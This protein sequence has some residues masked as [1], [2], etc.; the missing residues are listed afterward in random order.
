MKVSVIIPTYNY[1]RFL[2]ESIGSVQKQTVEDVEILVVDDGSTDDTPEIVQSLAAEDPRVEYLPMPR[3]GVS[4][5]RNH[6]LEHARG[7]FIAYLDADDRW[8]PDKLEL[9]LSMM[10]SEP[11]LGLVFTNALRFQGDRFFEHDRLTFVPEL[12][13]VPSRPSNDGVGR[14]I[15]TDT[16]TSLI[17]C[18][19]LAAT[20]ST[21]LLRAESAGDVRWKEGLQKA[22]DGYY[23]LQVYRR[24]RAGYID[25]P[26]VEMRRHGDNSYT[27]R[28]ES[29]QPFICALC[30][31]LDE[32]G[33]PLTRSHREALLQRL[34]AAWCSLGY[35]HFWRR[36]PLRALAG[37]FRALPFPGSRWN[38]LAHIAVSPIVPF[39]PSQKP[40][41]EEFV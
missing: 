40:K 9:Q 7:E 33:E 5:A 20:P 3:T 35:Y 6:G 28:Y 4:D 10:R 12:W 39:L 25:K 23:F 17:P 34:G 32:P 26:L 21:A 24:V 19:M 2:R 37:Y 31:I 30:A 14:V 13:E 41:D 27:T 38:A 29:I 15:E 18:R 8:R 36:Q 22:P 11:E 1:G 16:F